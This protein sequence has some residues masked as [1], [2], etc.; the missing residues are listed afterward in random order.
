MKT[1]VPLRHLVFLGLC[2]ALSLVT[3]RVISPMTNILTD[4]IRIP[5]GSAATAFSLMFLIVGTSG[6]QWHWA[7]TSAALVQSLIALSMGMS[8]YQ[9]IMAIVTYSV[10]GL[11]ID[12]FRM[13][14]RQRGG[15]Y[16]SLCCAAAN[17]AGAMLTNLLVFLLKGVAFLLW[18]LV[19]ASMGLLAGL[20]GEELYRR[21]VWI[22]EI[23]G[24]VS[25]RKN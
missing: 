12:L 15:T 8:S 2:V 22:T 24:I 20:I 18:V 10:P 5:G 1:K 6:L 23:R 3:K 19:A 14:W 9:G 16:F 25:C 13:H 21:L 4:F 7:A 11:V 17:I